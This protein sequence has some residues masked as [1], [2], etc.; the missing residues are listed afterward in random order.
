VDANRVFDSA[1][2]AA[3]KRDGDGNTEA[4]GMFIDK[5]VATA[6]AFEGKRETT[7]LI[8]PV[9]VGATDVEEQV[10]MEV[11]K[12]LHEVLFEDGQVVVVGGAIREVE[13][14][15]GGGL[16]HGVVVLLMNRKSEDVG[17]A[18]KDFR[19]AIAVV[20]VSIDDHSRANDSIS[21]EAADSN[22]DIMNHA[23]AFAVVGKGVVEAAADAR[24][25]AIGQGALSGEDGAAGGKPEGF[26]GFFRIRDFE[27]HLLGGR[28]RASFKFAD[29][30]L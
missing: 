1:R 7:Q 12:R 27:A 17:V 15:V 23:E 28:E 16:G 19:G 11:V 25:K 26:D 3:G 18:S 5:R 29:P 24:G 20:N 4:A 22:G 30:F 8:F 14:D 21:L 6:E 13:I 10:R 2:V 9:G